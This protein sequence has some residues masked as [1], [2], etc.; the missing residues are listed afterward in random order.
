MV[1]RLLRSVE[2]RDSGDYFGVWCIG[3]TF[4]SEPRGR[5]FDSLHPDKLSFQLTICEV[6]EQYEK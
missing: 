4:G 1:L 3:G 6:G 5:E 2:Y